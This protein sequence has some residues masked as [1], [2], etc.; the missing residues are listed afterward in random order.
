[1]GFPPP[2][3]PYKAL[4][5]RLLLHVLGQLRRPLPGVGHGKDHADGVDGGNHNQARNVLPGKELRENV[6]DGAAALVHGGQG[7]PEATA[8]TDWPRV[9]VQPTA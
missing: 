7:S 1:M 4:L 8:P 6:G 3:W 9:V 5:R 2:E